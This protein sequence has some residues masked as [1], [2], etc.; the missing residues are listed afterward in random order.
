MQHAELAARID[1]TI[2]RPE[3]TPDE[4]A[5]VCEQAVSLGCAAAVV[6]PLHLALCVE[7]VPL[8]SFAVPCQR[9]EALRCMVISDELLGATST[10]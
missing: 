8:P 6:L 9:A 10:V 2:L 4:V 1:S 7:I 5:A 3:A